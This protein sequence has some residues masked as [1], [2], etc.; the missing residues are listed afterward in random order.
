MSY[1]PNDYES[2]FSLVPDFWRKV[3]SD[4]DALKRIPM[5]GKPITSVSR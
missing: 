5:P 4:K 3:F 2:I 1:N